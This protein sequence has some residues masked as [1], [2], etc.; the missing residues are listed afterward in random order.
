MTDE[1]QQRYSRIF[2]SGDTA[3]VE[4][5]VGGPL[6]LCRICGAM[7][8]DT[9]THNQWHFSIDYTARTAEGAAFWTRR[10]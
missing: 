3:I 8:V 5:S 4:G 9:E 2:L 10:Y 1:T 7:V 6:M